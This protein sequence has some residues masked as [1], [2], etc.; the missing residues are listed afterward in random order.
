[1]LFHTCNTSIAADGAVNSS[2]WEAGYSNRSLS[3]S[4]K[5]YLQIERF[6]FASAAALNTR[7]S[8]F[9]KNSASGEL[10]VGLQYKGYALI[11]FEDDYSLNSNGGKDFND[12][13]FLL[14]GFVEP[15]IFPEE[16][17]TDPMIYTL[18]FEDMGSI[19]DFDF[20]DVVLRI[21]HVAGQSTAHV[22]L[23][24][25]GGNL[26]A[27]VVYCP[28]GDE[29]AETEVVTLWNEVHEAFGTTTDVFINTD[30][31]NGIG[32]TYVGDHEQGTPWKA[33]AVGSK[34]V[35]GREASLFRIRVPMSGGETREVTVPRR[36][37]TETG[38]GTDYAEAPQA[39][40][41]AGNWKWPV[42]RHNIGTGYP[43]FGEWGSNYGISDWHLHGADEHL[44]A[45]PE[46][47][48]PQ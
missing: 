25:A 15:G 30:T 19:G 46:S 7:K 33:V 43:G 28:K 26:P 21:S 41:V 12:V 31:G 1:M 24:A 32:S 36:Y 2:N 20:N 48:A 45:A 6:T 44:Y 17:R 22:Q 3:P 14:N 16:H 29:T 23:C 35:L 11:G 10:T 42:E 9:V 38:A 4:D 40:V 18:A 47:V 34:F 27:K 39:I 37:N 8:F 13:L 5:A